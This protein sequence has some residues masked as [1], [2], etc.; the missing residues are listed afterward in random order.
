MH[1]RKKVTFD[2]IIQKGKF[3]RFFLKFRRLLLRR[4]RLVGG[5][6]SPDMK[7]QT[8]Q[9]S[10]RVQ[11]IESLK[12][13]EL[14]EASFGTKKISLNFKFRSTTFHRFVTLRLVANRV[15]KYLYRNHLDTLARQ[16]SAV[17]D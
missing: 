3:Y 7:F 10:T 4:K 15:K 13:K 5:F 1:R 14:Y 11:K 12:L 9:S 6:I 2:N 8:L 17:V 16:Q